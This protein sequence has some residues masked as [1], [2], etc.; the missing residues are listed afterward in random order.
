MPTVS[1]G[2]LDPF[3]DAEIVPELRKEFLDRFD[4]RIIFNDGAYFLFEFL[5]SRNPFYVLEEMLPEFRDDESRCGFRRKG[6]V[7]RGHG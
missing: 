2:E 6:N 3:H 7:G 5:G 1:V 4:E